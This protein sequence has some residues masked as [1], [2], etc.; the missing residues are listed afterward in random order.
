MLLVMRR[1]ALFLALSVTSGLAAAT[2]D[3]AAYN[4]LLHDHVQAGR[5][6]YAALKSDP[7]LDLTVAAI[8]TADLTTLEDRSERLA[9]WLNAYNAL[10]LKLVADHYPVAS[11]RDIADG[12]PWDQ[13]VVTLADGRTLTLNQIEHEIIRPQFKEPRVHFAL[14]CAAA[15]CPP[16]RSE[17]YVGDRLEALLED[18]AKTFLRDS[19]KN[20]YDPAGQTLQV[21]AIFHWFATDFGNDDAALIEFVA[22]YLPKAP[23]PDAKISTLDYDW[24]LNGLAKQ[25]R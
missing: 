5:V 25:P 11:I 10:T 16:L 17:A 13:P 3:W 23:G 6:D 22:P 15:S 8:A 19:A 2:P 4:A 21:N 9:F 1:L 20:R 14:V 24:S 12:K 7:R 18:Q